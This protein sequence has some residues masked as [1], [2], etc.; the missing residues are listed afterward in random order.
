M[1]TAFEGDGFGTWSEEGEAFG[2]APATPA[3]QGLLGKVQGFANDSLAFSAHPGPEATGVLTSPEF[4]LNLPYISFL[5]GG[6]RGS[7]GVAMELVVGGAVQ[8]SARGQG[9]LLLRPSTWNVSQFAGQEARIRIVDQGRGEQGFIMVDHIVFTD[10]PNTK[11]PAATRGGK[12][13]EPGLV[14][15][16]VIPGVTIPIGSE[17]GIFATWDDHQLY[18]PTALCFDEQNRMLVAETHRL[19]YGVADNRAH[20]YWHTDDIALTST[21]DRRRMHEKWNHKFPVDS[22]TEKSE[23]VRLLQDTDGDGVADVSTIFADGFNDL[24]DGTA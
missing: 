17:L 23:K 7:D 11:F 19:R 20:R 4:T 21:D 10:Y 3:D 9:D 1:F 18:S 14:A 6:G 8:R 5:V 15:T 13:F 12:P 16:E 22:M 24:L 2:K